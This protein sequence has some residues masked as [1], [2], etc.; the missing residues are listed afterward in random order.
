MKGVKKD[1]SQG[2]KGSEERRVEEVKEEE[3]NMC[4]CVRERGK[5]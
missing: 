4:V 5:L 1:S 3:N 2:G